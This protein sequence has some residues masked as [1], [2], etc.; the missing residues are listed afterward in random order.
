MIGMQINHTT[1]YALGMR[2]RRSPLR[3]LARGF[4]LIEL[5]VTIS[6]LAIIVAIGL[7]NLQS[8][9]VSNRLNSH[10]NQFVGLM[11]YARSEAIVRNAIVIICAKSTSGPGCSNTQF[12][13]E[14][15]IIVCLDTDNDGDCGNSEPRLRTISPIDSLSE[16]FSL[17]A[18]SASTEIRFLPAGYARGAMNFKLYANT[19]DAAYE[20]KYGRLICLSKP[21]RVRVAPFNTTVCNAS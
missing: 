3:A 12:W 13:G 18:P 16:Q 2:I 20:S 6:V 5:M 17:V 11:N 10:V 14:R 21:G 9:V 19:G 15:T 7:P 4:T 8:F 1:R